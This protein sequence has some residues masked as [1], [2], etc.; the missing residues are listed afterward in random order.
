MNNKRQSFKLYDFYKNIEDRE[1]T[2]RPIKTKE[3]RHINDNKQ[4]L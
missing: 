4:E 2:F 1:E 3:E